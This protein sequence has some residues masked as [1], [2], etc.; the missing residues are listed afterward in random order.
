MWRQ[1][2][3]LA[4]LAWLLFG[5]PCVAVQAQS[6]SHT[7]KHISGNSKG[8][9]P[10]THVV[11]DPPYPPTNEQPK[12]KDEGNQTPKGWVRF[13]QPDW[14]IV[15]VTIAYSAITLLLWFTV[16]RQAKD[17]RESGAQNF[18][19]LKEQ[20]DNLLIS[21]KAATVMAM[22]ADE[23]SKAALAQIELVK[24]KER[25][26]L[27]VD[28][29]PFDLT[30]D[31]ELEGY[32]IR[33]NVVLDG[34]TRAVIRRQSIVAYLADTWGTKRTS[35]E[36]LGI[37]DTFTPEMSPLPRF[38][39]IQPDEDISLFAESDSERITL[40][41]QRKLDVYVRGTVIYRDIFGDE[42]EL[43]IDRIWHQWAA[44]GDA[45]GDRGVWAPAGN[46]EG[47]YHRQAKPRPTREEILATLKPN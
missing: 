9:V 29:A 5:G 35:W 23:S 13:L 8:P 25:A 30:Y 27:R 3:V 36:P 28:F 10:P 18:K 31:G 45:R 33:F 16:R 40:V 21:A 37:P 2:S 4:C 32:P 15:Y 47:D 42:W 39:L 26:Q 19:I 38:T 41:R 11:I 34:I 14:V 20:T 22:A 7:G 44:Y 17:A 43:G 24:A 1:F 6:G 12:T 46:G